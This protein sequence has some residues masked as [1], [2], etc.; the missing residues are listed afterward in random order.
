MFPMFSNFGFRKKNKGSEV[1]LT[2]STGNSVLLE[3]ISILVHQYC[4]D[5]V[6]LVNTSYTCVEDL[7]FRFEHGEFWT[8]GRCLGPILLNTFKLESNMSASKYKLLLYYTILLVI[9]KNCM[10]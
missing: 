5:S 9:Y 7:R 6:S 4:I 10:R 8:R 3:K 1:F 2:H